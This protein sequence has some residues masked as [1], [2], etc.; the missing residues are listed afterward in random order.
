MEFNKSMYKTEFDKLLQNR[1]DKKFFIKK[2]T[3][4]FKI[5]KFSKKGNDSLDLARFI[6]DSNQ[7][8]KV[9]GP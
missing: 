3:A 4:I 1:S 6:K 8:A 7:A 9:T 5:N 2:S